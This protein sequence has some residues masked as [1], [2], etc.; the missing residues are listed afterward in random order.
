MAY[1]VRDTV[2]QGPLR[3]LSVNRHSA[4]QMKIFV[5]PC[6]FFIKNDKVCQK[7]Q[8]FPLKCQSFAKNFKFFAFENLKKCFWKNAFKKLKFE[9]LL[10]IW[11]YA[12]CALIM[13]SLEGVR[14]SMDQ[15][16]E[17][18]WGEW[19][20]GVFKTF[21]VGEETF[22]PNKRLPWLIWFLSL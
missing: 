14:G 5:I 21:E 12:F 22:G 20:K 15:R 17:G 7:C 1:T 2:K 4:P 9:K 6:H 8:I 3:R 10:N 18:W 13:G 19:V 11:L 16:D